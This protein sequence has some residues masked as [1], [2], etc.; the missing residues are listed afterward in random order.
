MG[1]R[2]VH[3]CRIGFGN[4]DGGGTCVEVVMVKKSF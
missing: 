4:R 1:F 2:P 3:V